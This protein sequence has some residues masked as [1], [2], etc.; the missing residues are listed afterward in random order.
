[1]EVLTQEDMMNHH[2]CSVERFWEDA[3]M[4]EQMEVKME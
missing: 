3:C 2:F 1:M 4:V